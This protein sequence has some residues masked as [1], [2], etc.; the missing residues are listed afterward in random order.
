MQ[1]GIQKGR[2]SMMN[3]TTVAFIM[4]WIIGTCAAIVSAEMALEYMKKREP[5]G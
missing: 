5:K 3:P 1:Q 2:E 4:G